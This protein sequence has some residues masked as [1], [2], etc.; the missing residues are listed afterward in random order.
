[1]FFRFGFLVWLREFGYICIWFIY[2][3]VFDLEIGEWLGDKVG[4]WMIINDWGL[5][6]NF[7]F[8]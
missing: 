5:I 8:F 4:F 6:I 1:M 7:V 2:Y 3:I